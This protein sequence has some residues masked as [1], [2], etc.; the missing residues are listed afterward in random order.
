MVCSNEDRTDA[1]RAERAVNPRDIGAEV[2]DEVNEHVSREDLAEHDAGLLDAIRDRQVREHLAA[3]ADCSAR[4]AAVQRVSLV[5]AAQPSPAMPADVFARLHATVTDLAAGT[6][7]APSSRVPGSSS[8]WDRPTMGTLET[9]LARRRRPAKIL[10]GVLATCGLAAA[11]GFGGYVVSGLSG[12]N[13]PTADAPMIV[14]SQGRTL[15][16]VSEL[17]NRSG[18]GPHRFSEAWNCAR[19]VT[20]G[21]IT[22]IRASVLNGR[23]GFLVFLAGAEDSTRVVFVSGCGTSQPSAG[24]STVLP[25]S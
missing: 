7:D 24:P 4:L 11:V 6:P 17:E 3:C 13:E 19:Q 14:Q 10:A 21:R 2:E 9:T 22:G 1:L 20:S 15:G 12:H 8:G 18:L 5:L 16:S 25:K 23:S